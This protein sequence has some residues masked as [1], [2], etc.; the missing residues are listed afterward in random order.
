MLFYILQ[1]CFGSVSP[2]CQ[3]GE[4]NT[5][6]NIKVDGF[7]IT[8]NVEIKNGLFFQADAMFKSATSIE[9][10]SIAVIL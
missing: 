4:M 3:W 10:K 8:V 9:I 6:I 7:I 2:Y 5:V 1:F